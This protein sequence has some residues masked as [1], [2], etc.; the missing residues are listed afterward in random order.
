MAL[1]LLRTLCALTLLSTL[2]LAP[3]ALAAGNG[4]TEPTEARFTRW[5]ASSPLASLLQIA[6]AGPLGGTLDL[7]G[8]DTLTNLFLGDGSGSSG[9]VGGSDTSESGTHTEPD[10][11]TGTPATGTTTTGSSSTQG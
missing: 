1:K 8:A 2:I 5:L 7:L 4:D 6:T 3:S 9:P 11:A 10:G